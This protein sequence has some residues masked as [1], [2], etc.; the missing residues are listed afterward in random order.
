MS[1]ED[2]SSDKRQAPSGGGEVRLATLFFF[3]DFFM[4]RSSIGRY[5]P[6]EGQI[7]PFS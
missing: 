2:I 7:F 4:S 5:H 3:S 6:T 1:A